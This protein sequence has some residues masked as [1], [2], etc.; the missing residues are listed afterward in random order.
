MTQD[1]TVT[2]CGPGSAVA[3]VHYRIVTDDGTLIL[4]A[5][6]ARCLDATGVAHDQGTYVVD[7]A[8]SSG[9]FAGAKGDGDFE[10]VIGATS[11]TATF[12]GQLKVGA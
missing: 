9:V 10:T 3:Q 5:S 8:A 12:T 4:R 1:R 6:A 7:G 11:N 2:T